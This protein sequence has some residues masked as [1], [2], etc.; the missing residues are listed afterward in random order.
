MA[1]PRNAP[2][3]YQSHCTG[4]RVWPANMTFAQINL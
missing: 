1:D 4:P 2:A 3:Q